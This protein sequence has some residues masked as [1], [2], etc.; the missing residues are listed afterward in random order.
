VRHEVLNPATQQIK[1]QKF[2]ECSAG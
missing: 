2:S 1:Q